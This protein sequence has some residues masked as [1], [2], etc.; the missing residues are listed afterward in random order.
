MFGMYFTTLHWIAVT[1]FGLLFALLSILA[2]RENRKNAW[3]L[4]FASFL[5]TGTGLFFSLFALDKYT[6]K[7]EI[8]EWK[9]R[10]DYMTESVM[11]MGKIKN[12]GAFPIGTCSVQ[13]TISNNARGF[14]H[15]KGTYFRP[16][17][18]LNNPFGTKQVS[19]NM[20]K[21]EYDVVDGL[22]PGKEKEFYIRLRF[23]PTFV[24]PTYRLKLTC[25]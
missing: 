10:R 15:K 14:K 5:L 3:G 18:G 9:H 19:S 7:G 11:I 2:W 24:D 4:I 1:V 20:L 8:V 22:A 13:L 16:S 17:R 12:V 23:P 6:K 25:H 21:K